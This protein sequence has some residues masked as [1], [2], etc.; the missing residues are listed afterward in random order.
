MYLRLTGTPVEIYTNLEP[1]YSDFRKLRQKTDTG[2]KMVY[3][4]EFIDILLTE[5]YYLGISFPHLDSRALLESK[6]LME[7]RVISEDVQAMLDEEEERQK[8]EEEEERKRQEEEKKKQE[9]ERDRD[10]SKKRYRSSSRDHSRERRRRRRSYHS[11]SSS[12]SS[13][14]H[15]SRHSSH[16]HHSHRHRDSRDSYWFTELCKCAFFVSYFV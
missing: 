10:Y 14:D 4:D 13:S 8:Q 9:K 12:R 16:R 5:K 6:G 2:Y 3:M 7:P 1:L 11:R 15:H